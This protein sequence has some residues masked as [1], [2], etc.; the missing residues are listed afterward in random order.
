LCFLHWNNF[1]EIFRRYVPYN[2]R[3]LRLRSTPSQVFYLLAHLR[4]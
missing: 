1:G 4:G 3:G 2:F